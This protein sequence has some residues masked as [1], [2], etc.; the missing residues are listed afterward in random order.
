MNYRKLDAA[1]AIAMESAGD[2]EE[3]LTVFVHTTEPTG[4]VPPELLD[5][6]RT[7]NVAAGI[8]T[9]S[10]T[11]QEVARLSDEPWVRSMRLSA[12]RHLT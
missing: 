11:R 8:Y 5:V 7:G 1:L 2:P 10:L 12:S 3:K 4:P 9:T 6:L